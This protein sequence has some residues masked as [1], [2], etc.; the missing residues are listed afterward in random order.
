MI[1]SKSRSRVVRVVIIAAAVHII[2]VAAVVVIQYS[3][4]VVTIRVSVVFN[5]R[6]LVYNI[7]VSVGL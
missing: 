3:S 2:V 4:T 6:Y 1:P 7:R 5:A